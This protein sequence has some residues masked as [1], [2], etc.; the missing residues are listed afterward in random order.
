MS[1]A[2]TGD[3]TL[4]TPDGPMRAYEAVPDSGA[5]TAVIVIPE[6]FGLNG[7][8]EDV[9]ERFAAAGHR[10]I[11]L[12]IFHRSGGGTAPYD[13]FEKV[14]PLF[15]GLTDD[16]LLDDIDAARSHLHDAG[17]DDGAIGIVG[18]CFGGR[19]TFLAAVRRALGASVGFYG[20][21]IVTTRFPQFPPLVDESASLQ[22]PWLGLFGDADQSIPIE[23]VERLRTTLDDQSAVPHEIVRYPEAEH[24][25]HC[26]QRPSY[27]PAAAKNGWDRTLDWF[28]AHLG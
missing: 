25:F 15:E 24:G 19:T 2:T 22:S 5:S 11:G 14:L 9:T 1:T 6:A 18:F 13:D 26:D 3:V 10:A 28:G 12:D 21:G 23:D 20:G 27:H 4:S 16:G 8:I 17:V 7:H